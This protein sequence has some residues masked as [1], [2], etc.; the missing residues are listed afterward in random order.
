[1]SYIII[2]ILRKSD[3]YFFKVLLVILI[4]LHADFSKE[5]ATDNDFNKHKKKLKI[6]QA[7]KIFIYSFIG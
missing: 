2:Y 7:T 5:I 4:L 6:K 1:M 3:Q